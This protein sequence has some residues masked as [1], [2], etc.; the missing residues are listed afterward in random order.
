MVLIVSSSFPQFVILGN[1][2]I[3]DLHCQ[4]G[5]GLAAFVSLDDSL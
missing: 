4:G 2:S 3:L 1:L 5:K